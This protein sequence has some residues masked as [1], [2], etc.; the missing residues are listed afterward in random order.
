MLYGYSVNLGP[1]L[2]NENSEEKL[3]GVT[4][5]K[6]AINRNSCSITLYQGQPKTIHACKNIPFQGCKNVYNGDERLHYLP[7]LSSNM[8]VNSYKIDH[9]IKKILERALKLAY[10]GSVSIF[11][12]LLEKN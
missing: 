6:K 3:I 12:Q 1:A 5:N 10:K 2:I 7:I 11:E 9:K 8:D 4:L